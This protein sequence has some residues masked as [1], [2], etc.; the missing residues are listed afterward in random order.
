MSSIAG[1]WSSQPKKVDQVAKEMARRALAESAATYVISLGHD[2]ANLVGR[3]LALDAASHDK[4]EEKLNTR[5]LPGSS[6]RGDWLS[7]SDIRELRQIASGVGSGD[8]VELVDPAHRLRITKSWRELEESR[9]GDFHRWRPQ[10]AGIVGAALG[11]FGVTDGETKVYSITAGREVGRDLPGKLAEQIRDL[12]H[13][14]LRDLTAAMEAVSDALV[15]VVE[16]TTGL[17]FKPTDQDSPDVRQ[18]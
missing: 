2:L 13:V 11:Q 14:A 6:D 4:L 15:P 8:L 7:L 1:T 16:R 3:V 12:V 5:L 18:T 10:S 17:R 9:G